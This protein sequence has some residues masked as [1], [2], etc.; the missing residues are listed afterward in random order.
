MKLINTIIFL[1]SVIFSNIS[2]AQ[3]FYFG[4]DISHMTLD[5]PE[6]NSATVNNILMGYEF[7]QW[8]IEGSY[9]ISKTRNQFY[10]GEQKINMYHLYSVYRSSTPLY[11]KVKLGIT[12][13]RYKFYN[14]TGSE[15]LDTTHT[16]I[17]RGIGLGYQY[18]RF[19]VEAEYTWLGLS[20][21]T[22]GLGIRYN[23]N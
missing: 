8:S 15:K 2:E 1:S 16:G 7:E 13:E 11:Y 17:A 10:G 6:F 3:Q 22:I 4:T 5:Q 21:E 14:A 19:N 9:N 23:F 18:G 20:I 12:H